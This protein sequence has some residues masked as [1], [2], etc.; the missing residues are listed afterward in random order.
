M[1]PTFPKTAWRWVAVA[2][3][4][5]FTASPSFAQPK[6]DVNEATEKAMKVASAKVAPTVVKI[7]TAGGAEVIPGGGPKKGPPGMPPGGGPA[8]RKGTGPTTGLIVSP[9]GYIIS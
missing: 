2:A 1:T 8:V 5:F 3:T 4:V 6:P 9:D 7:E